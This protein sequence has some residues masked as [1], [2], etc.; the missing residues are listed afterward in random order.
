M[1]VEIS[2]A[3]S[4][5]YSY[6]ALPRLAT[7]KHQQVQDKIF[8]VINSWVPISDNKQAA[9]KRDELPSLVSNWLKDPPYDCVESHHNSNEDQHKSYQKRQA[10]RSS[11]SRKT[12]K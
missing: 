9:E 2:Y 12:T 6:A 3:W 5:L 8:Q 4:T 10:S 7:E 1:F 11:G